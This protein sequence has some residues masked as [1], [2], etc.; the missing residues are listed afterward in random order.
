MFWNKF[1]SLKIRDA[2][3]EWMRANKF[4]LRWFTGRLLTLMDNIRDGSFWLGVELVDC[5]VQSVAVSR[6]PQF[7]IDENIS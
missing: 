6:Y 7:F 2:E 1:F 4:Q 3:L 5:A